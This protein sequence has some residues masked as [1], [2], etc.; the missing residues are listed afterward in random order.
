[1]RL[2][3]KIVIALKNQYVDDAP[4]DV[5]TV[6]KNFVMKNSV[7]MADVTHMKTPNALAVSTKI[8]PTI[9]QIKDPIPEKGKLKFS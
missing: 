5:V 6:G 8:S 3:S 2:M 1:M 9:T 7:I 4:T